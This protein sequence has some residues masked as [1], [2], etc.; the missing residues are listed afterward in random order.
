[1]LG[2]YDEVANTK[3]LGIYDRVAHAQKDVL[4]G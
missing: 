2:N 4:D 1:M 3:V